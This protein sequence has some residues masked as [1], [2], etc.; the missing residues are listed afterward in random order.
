MIRDD[1]SNRVV[2]LTKG[3]TDLEAAD[4]FRSIVGSAVLRGGTGYIKGKY[5]CVCFSEAP[6]GKLAHV[7][8]H[9]SIHGM[10]YAPLGV[11]MDKASLYELGGRPVIYQPD[12]DFDLLHASQRYRHKRYEPHSGVDFTWEREWRICTKA[13]DLDPDMVT[14]VVPNRRW[15]DYFHDC[16]AMMI[17]ANAIE[18][19]EFAWQAEKC[20]WHFLVLE[21]LGVH[22]P[23]TCDPPPAMW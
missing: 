22:V 10:Q 2:H 18:L 17:R 1:L 19:E 5:E 11:M 6:I 12:T 9:P 7:L 8:S 4:N 23:F 20:P 21:D 3:G 13:L 16:H 14:L 15:A